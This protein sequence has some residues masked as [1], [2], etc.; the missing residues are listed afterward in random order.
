L[1]DGEATASGSGGTGVLNYLWDVNQATAIATGLGDGTYTVTVTDVN[2]CMDTEN[3]TLV[4]PDQIYINNVDTSKAGA[5][6][7]TGT[8]GEI[9]ISAL[10]GTGA[11]S[12]QW[13]D[14]QNQGTSTA[15]TLEFG[16]YTITI[17]DVNGCLL[18]D[19]FTV[20]PFPNITIDINQPN[21]DSI[22]I[23]SNLGNE[24]TL[25][26]DVIEPTI[27]LVDTFDWK[28]NGVQVGNNQSVVYEETEAGSYEYD[29]LVITTDGCEARDQITITVESIKSADGEDVEVIIPNAFSPNGNGENDIFR[30][31]Y[32]PEKISNISLMLFDIQGQKVYECNNCG[33]DIGWDGTVN[34]SYQPVGVYRYIL[35][36]EQQGGEVLKQMGEVTL[37]R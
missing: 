25:N 32:D 21:I 9:V 15:I 14:A 2:G 8:K 34:S 11:L 3:T 7:D 24:I 5:C 16:V 37:I 23:L 17:I 13:N 36:Y 26:V 27:Q 33:L 22:I 20:T 12:Y 30:P 4:E 35:T 1:T 28:R 31:L 10:G 29:V 19:S 18:Q 6:L